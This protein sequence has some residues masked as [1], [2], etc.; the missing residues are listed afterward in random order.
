[1]RGAMYE[2]GKDFE[3]AEAAFRQV[4]AIEP[5]NAGALN[6]L[7]YMFADRNVRLEEAGKLIGRALELDPQNGAYLDSLGWVNFRQNKLPEAESLLLRA[8]DRIGNDPTVHDHLGDVYFKQGKTRDA[9]NQWQASLKEYESSAQSDAD[10]ADVAKV[11]KKLESAR[12]RLAREAGGS[13]K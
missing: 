3:R 1:M 10:P 12:V 9:I 4:L 13:N 2:K 5:D 6:Y 7:G 11:T 8:L